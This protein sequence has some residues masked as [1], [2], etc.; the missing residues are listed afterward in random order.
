MTAFLDGLER[1]TFRILATCSL[2]WRSSGS[3]GW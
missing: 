3:K 2:P 1:T